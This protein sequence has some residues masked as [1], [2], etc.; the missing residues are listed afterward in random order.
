M[1]DHEELCA[2][3]YRTTYSDGTKAYVN[4][5][6]QAVRIDCAEIPAQDYLICE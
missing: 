4:Y 6:D 2:G 5:T 1:E 3:V